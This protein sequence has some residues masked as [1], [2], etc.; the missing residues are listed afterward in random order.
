MIA[1]AQHWPCIGQAATRASQS[2]IAEDF[3]HCVPTV[4]VTWMMAFW[5][6]WMLL[7]C[8]CFLHWPCIGRARSI[9]PQIASTQDCDTIVYRRTL[10]GMTTLAH[11]SLYSLDCLIILW[12]RKSECLSQPALEVSERIPQPLCHESIFALLDFLILFIK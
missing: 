10:S 6:N 2:A 5:R 8:F 3:F 11:K 1:Q 9:E 4:I 12:L 7:A